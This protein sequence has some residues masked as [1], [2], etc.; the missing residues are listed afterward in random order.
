MKT[1]HSSL[2]R[3]LFKMILHRIAG[4]IR[5]SFRGRIVFFTLLMFASLAR[6]QQ[7]FFK[8]FSV[9]EGLAQSTVF[10]VIQDSHDIYWLGTQ[11][12]VSSFDGTGFKNYSSGDGLAENGVR[13]ICEDLSGNIWFGH[14]GGGISR[15]DG[16]QFEVIGSLDSLIK[17]NVTSL[18]V[19]SLGHLWITTQASGV[20]EVLN[21][22]EGLDKLENRQ[23]TGNEISDRVF[24]GYV[25]HT[26]AL[27]FVTD[28]NV[29]VYNRDSTRFD[30]V[31]LKGIPQYFNTTCVLVDRKGRSWFG[32]HNGGLYRYDPDADTSE[33]FDLIKAGLPSNFVSTLFEDNRGNIWAGTWG[34]GMVRIGEEGDLFLSRLK[35]VCPG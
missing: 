4:A 11:A 17:S 8:Q 12:G 5:P 16:K 13:A 31:I 1:V 18:V 7:L 27:Y 19:D 21:P 32:N 6:G 3:N 14:T 24:S 35:M 26:G 22:H 15:Y 29:K 34:G 9:S 20:I 28:L 10:K 33:M 25:D 2:S 30:N 23:Y